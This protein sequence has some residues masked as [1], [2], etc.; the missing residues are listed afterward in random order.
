MGAEFIRADR[1]TDMKPVV[2]FFAIVRMRLKTLSWQTAELGK[3]YF[4][5]KN[6][7]LERVAVVNS[8]LLVSK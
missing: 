5:T 3:K 8:A 1:R 4:V 6:P 2:A 7:P